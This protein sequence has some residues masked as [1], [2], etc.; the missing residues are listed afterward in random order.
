M[1]DVSVAFPSGHEAAVV[2][3]P[4]VGAFDLPAVAAVWVAAL[5]APGRFRRLIMG[6]ICRWVRPSRLAL[7][8]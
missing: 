2:A 5:P 7:A 6:V 4:G 3:E 1:V 8:S